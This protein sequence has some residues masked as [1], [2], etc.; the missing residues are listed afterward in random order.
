MIVPPS[1][2]GTAEIRTADM[3]KLVLPACGTTCSL[4]LQSASGILHEV[5]GEDFVYTVHLGALHNALSPKKDRSTRSQD[6]I[7]TGDLEVHGLF[8]PC[9]PRK[10]V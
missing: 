3:T 7:A 6:L 4:Q 9:T 1:D 5:R 8:T 2:V 10:L